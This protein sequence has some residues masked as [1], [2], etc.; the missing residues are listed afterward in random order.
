MWAE[1]RQDAEFYLPFELKIGQAVRK[2]LSYLVVGSVLFQ[3]GF[4]AAA[5]LE[6]PTPLSLQSCSK[7]LRRDGV[8]QWVG[9]K[10]SNV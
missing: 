8:F 1:I 2:Q 10:Q 4:N 7:G 6:D 5:Q 9:K 3:V